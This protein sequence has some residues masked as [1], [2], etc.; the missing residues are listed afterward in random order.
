[1]D[2][3]AFWQKDWFFALVLSLSFALLMQTAALQGL[4]RFAYDIGLRGS[5]GDASDDIAV[6]AIDEKSLETIGRWPWPRSVHGDMVEVLATAG[7]KVVGH[8]AFFFEPQIDPGLT[9]LQELESY[10]QASGLVTVNRSPQGPLDISAGEEISLLQEAIAALPD[11]AAALENLEFLSLGILGA[12]EQILRA[13]ETLNGDATLARSMASAGN[14]VVPAFLTP[15]Q[16]RGNP[17]AELPPWLAAQGLDLSQFAVPFEASPA[18]GFAYPIAEIGEVAAG[19]GHLTPILD[20][21]GAARSEPLIMDYFGQGVPSLSL[22]LAARTLNLDLSDI[23]VTAGPTVSLGNL[24]IRTDDALRMGIFFY[25]D[26]QNGIAFP[27]YSFSDVYYGVIPA[28]QFAGKT[29]LIGAFA[30]G[31]GASLVTPISPS[32]PPVLYL[33]HSVS[34]ILQEDFFTRPNW[35]VFVQIG[36]FVAVAGFLMAGL[37]RLSAGNGAVV[38]VA[39]LVLVLGAQYLAMTQARVW[40]PLISPLLLL[41]SGYLLLT[42]KRFLFT[43]KGKQMADL[44]SAESNR[45]LG[46]AFQGQGQLDMAFEKFRK[47]PKNEQ[48]AEAL[49]NL[50]LD[51][52]RKRQFGKSANVYDYIHSFAPQFKDVSGRIERSKQMESTMM[53]GMGG[54]GSNATLIMTG[55]GVQTPMLGRYEIEKEL[56][57]GAMGMVYKGKDPKIGRVVAIKTMALS[58]EF[59]GDELIEVKER[60]FREAETAGRLSHPNIVTMYDA[61]EEQD[62]AF[63]A[64][65][66]LSGTDLGNYVKKDKLLP[67]P[68][69]L[70]IASKCALALDYA[71]SLNVVHRDIK[72]ANV[73]YDPDTDKLKITDFGI[74]RI[75][76]A[77][78]TKTGTILG[79]PSYMAPEQLA[80]MK[81][82]GRA[83]LFSLGVMT[84]QMLT[85]ELPFTGDSLAT[86]MYRISNQQHPTLRSINPRLPGELDVFM[87]KALAKDPQQRFASGRQFAAG[88]KAAVLAAQ[89]RKTGK[90]NE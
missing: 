13:I 39:I 43:E 45:M 2:T 22:V 69:V 40:L 29:V 48:L 88:L 6:L 1:M 12:Q 27:V 72:P 10:L 5:G 7:A 9:Y 54:G 34:S 15:G 68:K 87:N 78:K 59:E 53:L 35:V 8:T 24:N 44:E 81:V 21:D 36:L 3:K 18:I 14:V 56:G 84:F 63:I 25:R 66:F 83:D 55:D 23:Q 71:H 70:E 76:D 61:G 50:A 37:P 90:P 52:E 60:F 17:D 16:P 20:V 73:M 86:L 31:L 46:L 33:A 74:A 65:E 62:L 82:D 67:A 47:C 26:D 30:A 38:S 57:K 85:G 41:L 42:T 77:S 49:Y 32:M 58:Q 80:G 75:T 51:Y 4:E 64:M 11:S 19:V 28:E 89:K 79:T